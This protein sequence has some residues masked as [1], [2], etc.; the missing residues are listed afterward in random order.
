MFMYLRDNIGIVLVARRPSA[1]Q[2]QPYMNLNELMYTNMAV[3]KIGVIANGHT[4]AFFTDSEHLLYK[5]ANA[6][7]NKLFY[8]GQ[9]YWRVDQR[10]QECVRRVEC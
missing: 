5:F 9:T 6:Y 10:A 4:W 8:S 3:L 2:P 7:L 1:G